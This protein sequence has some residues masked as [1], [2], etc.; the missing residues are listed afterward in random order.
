MAS[1]IKVVRLLVT[2]A[3]LVRKRTSDI[4]SESMNLLA[5][6]LLVKNRNWN[7]FCLL[8]YKYTKTCHL[9]LR[10]IKWESVVPKW[11]YDVLYGFPSSWNWLRLMVWDLLCFEPAYLLHD[12]YGEGERTRERSGQRK[13]WY[14]ISFLLKVLLLWYLHQ[15]KSVELIHLRPFRKQSGFFQ[16]LVTTDIRG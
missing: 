16:L 4:I 7:S 15:G 10:N 14:L 11:C 6:F 13:P 3:A 9:A 12:E 5:E 2:L 1:N 8:G